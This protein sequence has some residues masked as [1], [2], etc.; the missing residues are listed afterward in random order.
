MFEKNKEQIKLLKIHDKDSRMY[1]VPTSR[2]FARSDPG[3][4]EVQWSTVLVTIVLLT[5]CCPLKCVINDY[6]K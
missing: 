2:N 3:I 5:L 4:A 6:K 1:I